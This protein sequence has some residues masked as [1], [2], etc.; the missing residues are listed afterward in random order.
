MDGDQP[1]II[2]N[3]WG[4]RSTPSAFAAAENGALLVGSSARNHARANP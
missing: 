3:A 2:P 1:V 4:K